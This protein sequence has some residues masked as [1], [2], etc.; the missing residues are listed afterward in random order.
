M[1]EATSLETDTSALLSTG[2]STRLNINISTRLN[3]NGVLLMVR[4]LFDSEYIFG[5][6]E[7]GGEHH[8]KEAGR[9]GWVLF[10]EAIGHDPNNHS[11]KDFSHWSNQGY[12]VIC[13]LNN[14]YEPAR[15]SG[16]R[17]QPLAP[18]LRLNPRMR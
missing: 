1:V 9:L 16:H 12:G 4:P 2:I 14:G 8:M 3:I 10:T 5:L 18:L 7:P 6:H 15:L 17:L 13:R 11:G